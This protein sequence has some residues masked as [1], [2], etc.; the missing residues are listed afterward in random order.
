MATFADTVGTTDK[1]ARFLL[2][3]LDGITGAALFNSSTIDLQLDEVS[4]SATDLVIRVVHKETSEETEEETEAHG[5]RGRGRERFSGH[6]P[7]ST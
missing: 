7:E 4:S 5:P 1:P 3:G 6:H 2:V